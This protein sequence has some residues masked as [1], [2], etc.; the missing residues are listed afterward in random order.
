MR[1]PQRRRFSISSEPLDQVIA[2]AQ[3]VGDDGERW[4]YRRARRK[5]TAVH[6]IKVVDLMGLAVNVEGR[7]FG[8]AAEANRSVLM[9]HA[10]QRHTVAD[11]R[12]QRN[13]VIV[14]V[15]LAN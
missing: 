13:Q 5:E 2:G 11:E 8:V 10:G 14:A 3:S 9:R 7:G 12:I 1:V 4:V 6:D 15:G